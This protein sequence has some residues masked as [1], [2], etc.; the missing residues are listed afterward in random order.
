MRGVITPVKFVYSVGDQITVIC[1]Q[2]FFTTGSTSVHC[3]EEGQWSDEVPRCE[4]YME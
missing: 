1:D 2:G 4:D 3:T